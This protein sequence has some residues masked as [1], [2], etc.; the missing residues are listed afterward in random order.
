MAPVGMIS[1]V[2]VGGVDKWERIEFEQG[3]GRPVRDVSV[4][5]THW[6]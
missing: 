1:S 2:M 4:N 3:T 6:L 5:R